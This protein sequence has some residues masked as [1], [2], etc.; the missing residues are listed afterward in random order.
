MQAQMQCLK[1]ESEKSRTKRTEEDHASRVGY[2]AGP[3][4]DHVNMGWCGRCCQRLGKINRE[5][6]EL[7][8]ERV[9]EGKENQ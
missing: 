8:K 1:R 2:L 6:M 4:V 7:K 9:H 3:A 5:E